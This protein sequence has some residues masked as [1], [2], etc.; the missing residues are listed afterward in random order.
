MDKQPSPLAVYALGLAMAPMIGL[1]I[2]ASACAAAFTMPQEREPATLYDLAAE[3]RK[4]S[5]S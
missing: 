1:T 2:W 4:R 3:R 5:A